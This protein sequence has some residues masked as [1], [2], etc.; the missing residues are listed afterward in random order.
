MRE[1]HK[2]LVCV[3]VCVF[4]ISLF[5][6]IDDDCLIPIHSSH[7]DDKSQPIVDQSCSKLKHV[8]IHTFAGQLKSPLIV[9]L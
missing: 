2:N 3:C 4:F 7:D 6:G 5:M 1:I 8:G 9:H